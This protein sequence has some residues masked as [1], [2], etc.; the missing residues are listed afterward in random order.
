MLQIITFM[1]TIFCQLQ[2]GLP[3]SSLGFKHP[4]WERS[5]QVSWW[6]CHENS[7]M[8]VSR[9]QNQSQTSAIRHKCSLGRNIKVQKLEKKDEL[10]MPREKLFFPRSDRCQPRFEGCPAEAGGRSWTFRPRLTPVRQGK[11]SFSQGME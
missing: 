6:D 4:M 7:S 9:E 3:P 10:F 2:S 11:K 1:T 5:C 8:G